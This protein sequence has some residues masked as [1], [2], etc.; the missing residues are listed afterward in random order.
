[1]VC[2]TQ[3]LDWNM[4][5]E[6]SK[7]MDIVNRFVVCTLYL[8]FVLRLLLH[9]VPCFDHTTRVSGR[10]SKPSPLTWTFSRR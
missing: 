4:E 7:Q 8:L 2:N 9:A 5:E 3:S 10:R 6:E 1:M